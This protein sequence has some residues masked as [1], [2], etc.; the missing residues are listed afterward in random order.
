MEV[1]KLV[2]TYEVD[3]QCDKCG[4]KVRPTGVVLSSYPASYPHVCRKCG[5]HYIFDT[6]Y[7]HQEYEYVEE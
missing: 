4:D 3:M 1:K 6:T 2:K 7:P 5:E